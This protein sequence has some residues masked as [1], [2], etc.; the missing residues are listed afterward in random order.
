MATT[1]CTKCLP[2]KACDKHIPVEHYW[3]SEGSGEASSQWV[4][5]LCDSQVRRHVDQMDGESLITNGTACTTCTDVATT[6]GLDLSR[7][8]QINT[9]QCTRCGDLGHLSTECARRTW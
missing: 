3:Q 9:E 4:N 2:W 1:R 7:D 6:L 8:H 5:P